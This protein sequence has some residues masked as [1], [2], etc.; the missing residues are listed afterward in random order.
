MRIDY[1]TTDFQA[2]LK[3]VND[4]LR[5]TPD[6][7]DSEIAEILNTTE[8]FVRNQRKFLG[9]PE[10]V[11]TPPEPEPEP[12]TT[13]EMWAEIQRIKASTIDR[14]RRDDVWDNADRIR[15]MFDDGYGMTIKAIALKF[16]CSE[17]LIR[18][19]LGR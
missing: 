10:F 11:E 17:P 14:R 1:A 16:K 6:F 5:N 12:I 18:K 8:L 2:R 4:F 19:V 13:P 3:I 9:I 7:P 15:Q